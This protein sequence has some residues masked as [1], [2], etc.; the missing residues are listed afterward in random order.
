MHIDI[1]DFFPSVGPGLVF[2]VLVRNGFSPEVAGV[3]T[4][5]TTWRNHLAQGLDTSPV[6]ANLVLWQV[7]IRMATLA[8]KLGCDYRRYGDDLIFSGSFDRQCM[9]RTASAILNDAGF[10]IN[11]KKFKERGVRFQGQRQELLGLT[12]N[13][14]VNVTKEKRERYRSIVSR[15]IKHGPESVLEEG[16]TILHLKHRL[17]GYVNYYKSVNPGAAAA[18]EKKYKAIRWTSDSHDK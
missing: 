8:L 15:C 17:M 5:L 3:L 1:E 7:D 14:K 4:K 10:R 6:I 2:N 11:T 13:Q 12:V 18:L 16:E 9:L